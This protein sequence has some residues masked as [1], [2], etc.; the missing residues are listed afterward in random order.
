MGGKN[1]YFLRKADS[2][3]LEIGRNVR[4]ADGGR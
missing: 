2:K 4:I 1:L 3:K